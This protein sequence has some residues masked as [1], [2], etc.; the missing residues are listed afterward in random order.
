MCSCQTGPTHQT[1]TTRCLFVR[2]LSCAL[3]RGLFVYQCSPRERE[4][5][6]SSKHPSVPASSLAILFSFLFPL[7]LL[8]N[9]PAR[10][11]KTVV[12]A[13]TLHTNTLRSPPASLPS[14]ERNGRVGGKKERERP[15]RNPDIQGYHRGTPRKGSIQCLSLPFAHRLADLRYRRYD[16]NYPSAQYPLQEMVELTGSEG[17]EA[18]LVRLA[19]YGYTPTLHT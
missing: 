3:F 12:T 16:T 2:F 10:R 1:S 14:M 11:K 17:S 13:D 5:I 18:C 9:P 8:V 15:G 4:L 6:P 19:V 7:L